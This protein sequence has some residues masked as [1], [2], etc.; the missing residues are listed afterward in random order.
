MSRF[1]CPVCSRTS[2][3]ENDAREGY[4][5]ACH[6]WTGSTL[7][8]F[9][10]WWD[11]PALEHA[12]QLPEVPTYAQCLRCHEYFAE[13]D[14]GL[15]IPY[16]GGKPDPDYIVGI[17]AYTTFVAQHRECHL[18]EIV[19]HLVGVCSCTGHGTDRESARE[20]ARRVDGGALLSIGEEGTPCRP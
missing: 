19:G 13:G 14:Q 6:E 8:Y 5:G 16:I 15:V 10:Q 11:V 2:A 17:G 4:C 18:S 12:R 1:T 9:G 20:V 7:V 3:N